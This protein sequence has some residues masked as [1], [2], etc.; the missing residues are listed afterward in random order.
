[1]RAVALEIP[2]LWKFVS[3]ARGEVER[4]LT[5]FA[6]SVRAATVMTASELIENAMKYGEE[7]PNLLTIHLRLQAD[8]ERITIEVS[9]GALTRERVCQLEQRLAEIASSTDR[10]ELYMN[11]IRT[12]LDNPTEKGGLGL[13]RI[14]FEGGFD[15]T[16][17]FIDSIVTVTAVRGAHEHGI[18]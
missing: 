17:T 4:A 13:Y 12:L 18:V 7:V 1:M 6:P 14:G 15:L 3:H 11:R 16:C 10:E 8:A 2:H 9:N 5:S